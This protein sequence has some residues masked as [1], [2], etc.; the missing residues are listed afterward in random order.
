MSTIKNMQAFTRLIG[1]CTGYGGKYNPGRQT[2]HVGELQAQL[3]AVRQVLEE[4][5]ETKVHFNDEVNARK[6]AFEDLPKLAA[7][8]IR[9]LKAFGASEEK[10]ADARLYFRSITGR[11]PA[12]PIE[13]AGSTVEPVPAPVRRSQMQLAYVD[14]ADWFEQ[15]VQTASTHPGYQPNEPELSIEGLNSKVKE[16]HAC[17]QRVMDARVAWSNARVKRDKLIRDEEESMMMTARAVKDYLGAIFGFNS[18]EYGQ[19]KGIIIS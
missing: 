12:K 13:K 18:L 2:L 9:A 14:K 8:V 15:L 3:E 16:L 19:V 10:M 7:S 1:Y 17:N 4:V 6:Q 11:R 5:K